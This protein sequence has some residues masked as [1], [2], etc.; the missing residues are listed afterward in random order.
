MMIS[1]PI[2]SAMGYATLDQ[3]LETIYSASAFKFHG[4]KRLT[5]LDTV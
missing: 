2:K 5:L 1:L 3:E 4:G